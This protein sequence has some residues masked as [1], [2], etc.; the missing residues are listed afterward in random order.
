MAQQ[1]ARN[2]LHRDTVGKEYRKLASGGDD[3]ISMLF[4]KVASIDCNAV[5]AGH[6]ATLDLR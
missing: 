4:V 2:G 3:Y 6:S 1:A 5:H